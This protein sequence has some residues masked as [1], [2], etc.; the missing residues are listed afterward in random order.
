MTDHIV[1]GV[2]ACRAGWVGIVLGL[3]PEGGVQVLFGVDIGEL[4]AKIDSG[5][6]VEAIGI[7]MPIH[8]PDG[9]VRPC[10][11]EARRHL[12]GHKQSSLFITPVWAALRATA[13]EEA[14][15]RSRV[16]SGKGISRQAWALRTKILEVDAWLPAAPC[17]V[18]EV[19]PEISF[20]VMAGSPILDRKSTW[21]G[22]MARRSALE[23][24]GI[25]LPDDI[26]G[27]GRQAGPDDVLDAAAAA[28]S[29]RR[30]ATGTA[31]S[32]P[33]PPTRLPSGN[34]QAI[35]A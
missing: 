9:G 4:V 16:A 8:P 18:S 6:P 10:D 21:A 12:G 15:E 5:S 31:R 2:D 24:E 32:L 7:D 29:A 27:A 20:S 30:I 22:L 23:D 3:G 34:L 11:I 13:Y 26:G 33:D 28:W 25:S 35:W 14:L 1:L 17:P 19:H